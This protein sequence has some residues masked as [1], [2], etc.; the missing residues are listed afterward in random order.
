MKQKRH[1]IQYKFEQSEEK[2]ENL[3]K[4]Q[5]T[6]FENFIE[7]AIIRLWMVLAIKVETWYKSE[8]N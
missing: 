2:S 7:L 1:K 6:Y 8:D 4:T 3:F 5:Y